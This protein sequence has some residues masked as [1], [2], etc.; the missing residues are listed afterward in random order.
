MKVKLSCLL[1]L[2]FILHIENINAQDTNP[3]DVF[4]N[5]IQKK[6]H[7][8]VLGEER[9]L[10]IY[11]PDNYNEQASFPVL[12]ML[13]GEMIEPYRE[14]V[15][16]VKGIDFEEHIIVGIKTKVNRNRDMI[17]EKIEA[18]EGSGGAEYFLKF[19]ISELKPF[20]DKNYKTSGFNIL[21]GASNA[22]LFTIYA[23]LQSPA[24]FDAYIS[25]SSMIGH[26]S[27]FMYD[28]AAKT[29]PELLDGKILYI[30]WGMKDF[31]TQATE[32]LPDYYEMLTETFSG[33]L[34][35]DIEGLEEGEHVPAGGIV[36]GMKFIYLK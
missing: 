24:D 31:F 8:K 10:F 18:R 32:Y 25:S 9:T 36:A 3:S 11:L 6:I 30:H 22:G 4:E 19:L 21:Y 1:I 5:V 27:G 12:Y 26:C 29:N 15:N 35:S 23:L 33:Y 16:C 14:A 34:K 20:M 7:S 17:P 13:D 28:L 2:I